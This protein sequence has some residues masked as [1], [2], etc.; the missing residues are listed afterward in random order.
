MKDVT[1]QLLEEGVR[2]FAEPF[3]KLLTVVDKAR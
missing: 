3:E 1:D 2:L